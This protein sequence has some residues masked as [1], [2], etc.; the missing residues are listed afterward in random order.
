[1]KFDIVL[2]PTLWSGRTVESIFGAGV[3]NLLTDA[4]INAGV[5]HASRR[6]RWPFR[7]PAGLPGPSGSKRAAF[8]AGTYN[9]LESWDLTR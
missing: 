3:E 4:F 5:A 6:K 8:C 7:N 2:P 9:Y 1:M